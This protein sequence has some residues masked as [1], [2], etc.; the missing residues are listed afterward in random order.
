MNHS[1]ISSTR[2]FTLVELIVV[3]TILVILGTIAFL[4]LGG[5]SATARDAQRTSDL[6]QISTQIMI[7][8]AKQ[9]IAYTTM[10]SGTVANS[11]TGANNLGGTGITS[12]SY[13]GGDVNYTV[14]GID[15][16]KFS[17][18]VSKTTYKMAATSVA[19]GSYELASKLEETQTALVM[20][21]FK[22]RSTQS[23][24]TITSTGANNTILLSNAD[25]GKFFENDIVGN[26]TY[27]GTIN[28][29][30]FNNA[31]GVTLSLGSIAGTFGSTGSLNL[32][33][34]DST[35]LI[36]GLGTVSP[37]VNKGTILP[38]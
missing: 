33:K 13:L 2:G 23:A 19:G 12:T 26:G 34:T 37:V 8:Q 9:G 7:A 4:N 20:G 5:M 18:P 21:T 11:L 30:I 15:S 31:N 35:G 17:D 36:R 22:S 16:A 24:G 29:I 1:K 6:N 10:L 32:A 3:I 27:T 28:R 38:Y 25:I 14:L